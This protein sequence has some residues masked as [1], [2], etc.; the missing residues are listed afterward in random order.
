MDSCRKQIVFIEQWL[1]VLSK[2]LSETGIFDSNDAREKHISASRLLIAVGF[3][4]TSQIDSTYK[5]RGGSS[6]T[7]S[8]LI[9]KAMGIS[10][11]NRMD[12]ETRACCLLTAKRYLEEGGRFDAANALLSTAF[13]EKERYDFLVFI[14]DQ[15]SLLEKKYK[16]SYPI[17]AIIMPVCAKPLELAGYATGYVLGDTLGRS[18]EFHLLQ[19]ALTIILGNCVIGITGPSIGMGVMLFASGRILDTFCGISLAWLMGT[20]LKTVGQGIGFG[21]GIPLDLA[22]KLLNSARVVLGNYYASSAK[23]TGLSLIDGHPIIEGV[24]IKLE[25]VDSEFVMV[26]SEGAPSP[27]AS[28][29]DG[30]EITVT[31]DGQTVRL[32]WP[33]DRP[34]DMI[35]LE[36]WITAQSRTVPTPD[37]VILSTPEREGRSLLGTP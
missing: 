18:N 37:P 10:S 14:N 21:V 22:F 8:Q 1:T 13:K 4:I 23:L 25:S 5:V 15:C 6:A 32:P 17:T 3:Y 20:A 27:E 12:E 29:E 2:D 33:S 35:T 34:V 26:P 30:V 24:S 7:L 36:K 9:H 28:L 31:I 11:V 19:C 16:V